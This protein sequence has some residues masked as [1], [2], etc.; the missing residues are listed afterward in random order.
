MKKLLFVLCLLS[1]G[2][3]FAFQTD[4]T[5]VEFEDKSINRKITVS[6]GKDL[7]L[8]I[9]KEMTLRQVLKA[10]KVDSLDRE[11]VQVRIVAGENQVII[12]N[13]DGDKINILAGKTIDENEEIKK[14]E[15]TKKEFE[16]EIYTDNEGPKVRQSKSIGRFF[17]KSEFNLYLGVNTFTGQDDKGP[18]NLSELRVWPSRYIA[19]SVNQNLNLANRK[20]SHWVLS[21][22]PEFA[23]HNFMLENSNV[24]RYEDGQA[25]FVENE[26][27]TSK[28][29]FVIPHVNL[30]VMLRVGLKK[31]RI[32]FGVGGYIGYRVGGYTKE[33]FSDSKDRERH[34][35]SFGMNNF[36]YGLTAEIG[37]KYGSAL[38]IRYD[39]NNIF[40]DSQMYVPDM[41]AISFGIKIL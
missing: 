6:S 25:A 18:N 19:L 31:E 15:P 17:K 24:L 14:F 12:F 22:G 40:R 35:G 28:S 30:P 32:Y 33:K 5:I 7:L 11:K 26:E 1:A 36:K 38:F 21:F 27:S 9:P 3:L 8:V 10:F 2:K 39:L 29:K 20:W 41:K 23:W 4:S 16:I 34:K 13:K 37:H